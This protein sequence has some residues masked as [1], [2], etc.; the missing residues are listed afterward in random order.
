MSH[1]RQ[2]STYK[3]SGL[4]HSTYQHALTNLSARSA[5]A[6]QA[7]CL[8]EV[9]LV[10]PHV[11]RVL[12]AS[13]DGLGLVEGAVVLLERARVEGRRPQNRASFFGPGFDAQPLELRLAWLG[14]GLGVGLGL[15]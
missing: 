7:V 6:A 15:G 1:L 10:Q 5:T 3:Y 2:P 14:L 9:E 4:T 8:L 13:D 11:G 12:G